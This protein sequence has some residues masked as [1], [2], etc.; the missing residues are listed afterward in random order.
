VRP[1][2]L[3]LALVAAILIGS[4]V[5]AFAEGFVGGDRQPLE[6]SGGRDRLCLGTLLRDS[7]LWIGVNDRRRP[8][9]TARACQ[10]VLPE[11]FAVVNQGRRDLS[12]LREARRATE[13]QASRTERFSG[14]LLEDDSHCLRRI[15]RSMSWVSEC[16]GGRSVRAPPEHGEAKSFSVMYAGVPTPVRH[17]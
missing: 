7:L 1:V 5:P 6:W 3:T 4:T 15:H 11:F 17:I 13:G 8:A 14:G 2:I 10:Q 16:V 12:H 9:T